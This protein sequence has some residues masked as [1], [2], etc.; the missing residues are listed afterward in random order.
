MITGNLTKSFRQL[1]ILAMILIL[2]V[3]VVAV[4]T[5][6]ELGSRRAAVAF[7]GEL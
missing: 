3:V 7:A 4:G 2:P 6:P 1:A 5:A